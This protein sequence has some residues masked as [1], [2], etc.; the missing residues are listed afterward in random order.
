MRCDVGYKKFR[1][2]YD[3]HVLDWRWYR[4]VSLGVA[5]A[6]L[7][8]ASHCRLA[9]GQGGTAARRGRNRGA[10]PGYE[11]VDE[12]EERSFSPGNLADYGDA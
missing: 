5:C 1:G 12:D 8:L 3:D 4:R 6:A 10:A 9:T 2:M 7:G 11:M